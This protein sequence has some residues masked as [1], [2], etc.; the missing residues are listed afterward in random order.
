MAKRKRGVVSLYR[1]F[2]GKR[3]ELAQVFLTK[4]EGQSVI[5]KQ[6]KNYP[7][8][9]PYMRLVKVRQNLELNPNKPPRYAIRYALYT[10]K[11]TPTKKEIERYEELYK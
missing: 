8:G 5:R 2:N 6:I 1:T 7:V 9:R 3:Y 11:R 10:R 4:E